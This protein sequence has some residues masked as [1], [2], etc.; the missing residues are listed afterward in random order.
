VWVAIALLVVAVHLP[1]ST[2]SGFVT[3]ARSRPMEERHD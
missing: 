2:S 3:S 1:D